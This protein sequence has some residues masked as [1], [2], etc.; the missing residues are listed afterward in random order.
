M[1]CNCFCII[2]ISCWGLSSNSSSVETL[3]NISLNV[4]DRVLPLLS[5]IVTCVGEGLGFLIALAS[6]SKESLLSFASTLSS[7]VVA[8]LTGFF[9]AVK[10]SEQPPSLTASILLLQ[11]EHVL[12]I[13]DTSCFQAQ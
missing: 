4:I 12:P 2:G 8:F 11:Q 3:L 9:S 1:K 6:G 7:L 5:L 10:L 13:S